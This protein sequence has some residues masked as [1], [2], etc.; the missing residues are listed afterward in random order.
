M[1]PCSCSCDLGNVFFF[2]SGR[3]ISCSKTIFT[4]IRIFWK[5]QGCQDP[6]AHRRP[7]S[8]SHLWRGT[9]SGK[10]MWLL[11]SSDGTRLPCNYDPFWNNVSSKSITQAVDLEVWHLEGRGLGVSGGRLE[12]VLQP[13]KVPRRAHLPTDPRRAVLKTYCSIVFNGL[14][15]NMHLQGTNVNIILTIRCRWSHGRGLES[16]VQKKKIFFF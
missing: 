16:S 7:M 1:R 14:A 10:G 12:V 3:Q 15:P 13:P 2:T 11:V 9:C 5:I 6:S 8:Q 4:A